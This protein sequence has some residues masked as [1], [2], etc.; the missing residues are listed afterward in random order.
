MKRP[1]HSYDAPHQSSMGEY[2]VSDSDA[3]LILLK[4]A[5]AL[6]IRL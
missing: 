3:T 4:L 2:R 1:S 5:I 6:P